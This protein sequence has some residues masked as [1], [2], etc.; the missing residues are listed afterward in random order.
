[1]IE[2]QFKNKSFNETQNQID[3]ISALKDKVKP[4]SYSELEGQ[5]CHSHDE[6]DNDDELS[7]FEFD[8]EQTI[9]PE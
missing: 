8:D 9:S 3:Y 5:L 4:V 7:C 1:M 6:I 2:A